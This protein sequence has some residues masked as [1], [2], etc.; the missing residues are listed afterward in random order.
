MPDPITP[1]LRG[2]RQA[3]GACPELGEGPA[4]RRAGGG[5]PVEGPTNTR[6]GRD[7]MRCAVC[8]PLTRVVLLW[9]HSCV[10]PCLRVLLCS[11]A[12][13]VSGGREGATPKHVQRQRPKG[14]APGSPIKSGMTAGSRQQKLS[15]PVLPVLSEVEGSVARKREVEGNERV[16]TQPFMQRCKSIRRS[17]T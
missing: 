16:T 8:P 7:P 9:I 12:P 11:H 14:Q 4:R 1:P 13:L 2:S 17:G 5:K 10:D 3:Q 15:T 6:R